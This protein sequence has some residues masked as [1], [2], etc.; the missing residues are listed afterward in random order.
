MANKKLAEYN[1]RWLLRMH[2][3]L[4]QTQQCVVRALADCTK[5]TPA[6]DWKAI[7]K[8]AG[9]AAAAAEYAQTNLPPDKGER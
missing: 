5:D 2:E 9:A 8:L 3:D 4:A 1:L 6:V 7:T